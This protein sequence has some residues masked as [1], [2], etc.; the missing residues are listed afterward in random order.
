MSGIVIAAGLIMIDL[1]AMQLVGNN[2]QSV[3]V[4]MGV[5]TAQGL[6]YSGMVL[7]ALF[8]IPKYLKCGITTIPQFYELRYDR[9]T[10]NLITI[11]MMVNYIIVMIP[12]ALYTGAKVFIQIYFGRPQK[13]SCCRYNQ[14]Y[15]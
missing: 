12:S 3:I 2:G 4:G 7:A 8:L 6:G 9:F 13:Y 15:V 5:L 10:R 1:S 14:K 11:I